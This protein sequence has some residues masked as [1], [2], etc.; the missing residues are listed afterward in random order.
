MIG[1]RGAPAAL[2]VAASLCLCACGA[3][4]ANRGQALRESV[5]DFAG[6][7]RWGRIERAAEH[8]P[9]AKRMQFIQ[10]KRS[11]QAQLQIHEYDIRAVHYADGADKAR[12]LIAAVWSR[13]SDPVTHEDLFDQDWRWQDNHW[14]MARQIEVKATEQTV[15][16]SDAL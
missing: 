11:G 7:M 6:H 13:Q 8:V 2:L 9:D 12:V 3:T 16:P 1:V 14:V 15:Q 4:M 5:Q 10:Q